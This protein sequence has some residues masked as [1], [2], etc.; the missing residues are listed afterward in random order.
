MALRPARSIGAVPVRGGETDRLPHGKRQQAKTARRLVALVIC[1]TRKP[2]GVC[3][4][5]MRQMRV[6]NPRNSRSFGEELIG[7]L[8]RLPGR[9]DEG[10]G[11][12]AA[13]VGFASFGP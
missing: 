1:S 12:L 13:P 4:R 3:T 2:S 9:L 8:G 6:T 11:K 7:L 10:A 5:L